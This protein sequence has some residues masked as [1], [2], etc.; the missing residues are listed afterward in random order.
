[1]AYDE[2]STRMKMFEGRETGKFM[3]L[4]PIYIRLDGKG[5]S[6]FTKG[7]DRPYD[8]RM[9]S[10]M[11]KTTQALVK[12]TGAKIG[13]TQSDEISLILYSDSVDSQV[14]F[15]GKKQKIVSVL[16]SMATFHFNSFFNLIFKEDKWKDRMGLFDARAFTLPNKVE[17]TNAVLWREQDA[18]KNAI[19]MAASHYFSH[20][21]LHGKNGS[22][23]QEML[24]QE[25]GVNFNDYLAEFKRGI[26]V[27]RKAVEVPVQDLYVPDEIKARMQKEGKESCTRHVYDMIGMPKFSTVTNRTEVIFDGEDPVKAV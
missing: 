25:H 7:M 2:F 5:F 9:Q 17:A 4:L 1:M 23:M 10:C 21:E 24:W 8:T 26:F 19:Q 11:F 20:K 16:A 15:N 22:E 27:Q 6:K 3:P 14:Y 13:Y 12:A 18:T